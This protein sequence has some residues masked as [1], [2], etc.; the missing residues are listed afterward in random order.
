MYKEVFT[1]APQQQQQQQQQ[2]IIVQQPATPQPIAQ[3]KKFCSECGA[4]IIG[5]VKFCNSCGTELK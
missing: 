3:G 5:T 2:V 1:R 4:E